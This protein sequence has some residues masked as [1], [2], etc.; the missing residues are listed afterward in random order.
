MDLNTLDGIDGFKI[1]GIDRDSTSE[2]RRIED[3]NGDKIDEIIVEVFDVNGETE[4]VY[5]IF[6]NE[7]SFPREL[8]LNTLD[9]ID[10]F[11]IIAPDLDSESDSDDLFGTNNRTDTLITERISENDEDEQPIAEEETPDED[12]QPIAEEETLDGDDDEQPIAEEETLDG[13]DD[14]QPIAEEETLDGDGEPIAEE[15]TLDGDDD[16]PVAEE[17]TLD[18]DGEPIAEEETLDGEPTV[19]ETPNEVTDFADV[20]NTEEPSST[21]NQNNEPTVTETLDEVTEKPNNVESR[22]EA[23]IDDTQTEEI[24][25]DSNEADSQVEFEVE[26]DGTQTEEIAEDTEVVQ[27]TEDEA[28]AQNEEEAIEEETEVTED[29]EVESGVVITEEDLLL[30]GGVGDDTIS[31][32]SG[33]D[34]IVAGGDNDLVR[35]QG[36][37]DRIFGN[38]G[39]DTLTGNFGDDEIFG[40]DGDDRLFGSQGNDTLTG[41]KGEDIFIFL[42]DSAF[43]SSHLGVDRIRDFTVGEDKI[44]LIINTFKAL[45]DIENGRLQNSDLAIISDNSLANRSSAKIIYNSDSG[46]L[47]YNSDSTGEF[48]DENIFAQLIGSPDNL[49]AEDFQVVDV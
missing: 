46:N 5:T 29:T 21:V 35:G 23:E 26:F 2:M 12:E 40:N 3:I 30:I 7:N 36:G 31:G 14:E 32:D 33:N 39:N 4:E 17:E 8:D 34:L 19:T 18:G 47:S 11:K 9:G 42:M 1:S 41:G 49:S 48:I 25:V 43:D 27:E 13:D 44:L 38:Q 22:A 16:E 6:S 10:G 45:E 28:L 20:P 37:S 15:E 24:A